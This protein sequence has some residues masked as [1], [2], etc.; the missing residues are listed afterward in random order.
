[1]VDRTSGILDENGWVITDGTT[2]LEY[3]FVQL[4]MFVKRFARDDSR[5]RRKAIKAKKF[6]KYVGHRKSPLIKKI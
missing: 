2:V 3:F 4:A 1:M 5:R 6:D